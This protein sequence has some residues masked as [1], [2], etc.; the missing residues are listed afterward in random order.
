MT[1]LPLTDERRTATCDH[2][3]RR[4][5]AAVGTALA[6]ALGGFLAGSDTGRADT[7]GGRRPGTVYRP[8]FSRVERADGYRLLFRRTVRGERRTLR[9]DVSAGRYEEDRRAGRSLAGAFEAA[10]TDP[11]AADLARSL[12]D[13]ADAVGVA[14]PIE[15]V[16]VAVAFVRALPYATD[17][18]SAGRASYPRHVAE[19]LVDHVGDCEDY[20]AVL[21]GVLASAPFDLDP[22]L[23]LLPG[24]AGVGV[25]PGA[26]GADDVPPLRAAGRD[27]LYLDPTYD[28]DPGR[29]PDSHDTGVVALRHRGTWLPGDPDAMVAHAEEAAE[30][31]RSFVRPEDR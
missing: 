23:V 9:L 14:D 15:R 11:L 16:L 28:V 30:A 6:G 3:R 22:A 12:A 18:D 17:A 27:Y 24:H 19:T 21:A 7:D 10:L 2:G 4:A 29:L 31:Y 8:R 13:T 5:L 1:T 25:D 20:A 26:V